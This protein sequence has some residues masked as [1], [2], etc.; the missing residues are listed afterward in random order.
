MVAGVMPTLDWPGVIS[1]GQL[2][3]IRRVP[4]DC[5]Y[6]KNSAVSLTGTPSVMIT[7]RGVLDALRAGHALDD[8]FGC[9]G[10]EDCHV[11]APLGDGQLGGLGR[12]AVHGLDNGH[13]R[14]VGGRQDLALL[15]HVAAV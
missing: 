4:L 6:V 11:W 14:V 15:L 10:E 7:A 3:P 1:P 9:C 13:E 12:G 5:A 8:D 2:G